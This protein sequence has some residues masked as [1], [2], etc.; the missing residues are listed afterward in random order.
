MLLTAYWLEVFLERGTCTEY[1]LLAAGARIRGRL[2]LFNDFSS[3]KYALRIMGLI[4]RYD[5]SALKE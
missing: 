2:V 5:M 4:A 1:R 3:I